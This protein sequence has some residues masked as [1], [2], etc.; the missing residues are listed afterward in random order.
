M[1]DPY[2]TRIDEKAAKSIFTVPATASFGDAFNR[3]HIL[4]GTGSA[5]ATATFKADASVGTSFDIQSITSGVVTL[6]A[7]AGATLLVKAAN[8]E[9]TGAA[10]VIHC[11]CV[12]NADG[13][14]AIWSIS[15]DT[16]T[17]G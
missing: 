3:G 6:A 17:T 12:Q 4:F 15:G 14:S 16:S 7:A 13:A 9:M 1:S 11:V 5:A 2:F 8:D 10:G